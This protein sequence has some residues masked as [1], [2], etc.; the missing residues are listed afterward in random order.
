VPTREAW[1]KTVRGGGSTDD[2]KLVVDFLVQTWQFDSG[3]PRGFQRWLLEQGL[4]AKNL[5]PLQVADQ[6]RLYALDQ[7]ARLE[8]TRELVEALMNGVH[9]PEFFGSMA[10]F[11]SDFRI[12][13]YQTAATAYRNEGI[14]YALAALSQ[15]SQWVIDASTKSFTDKPALKAF[16]SFS[17]LKNTRVC[18]GLRTDRTAVRCDNLSDIDRLFCL[19]TNPSDAMADQLQEMDKANGAKL[20]KIAE[21]LMKTLP[22]RGFGQFARVNLSLFICSAGADDELFAAAK[23]TLISIAE[24]AVADFLGRLGAEYVR[25]ELSN[26]DQTFQPGQERFV[27][28]LIDAWRRVCGDSIGEFEDATRSIKIKAPV[29]AVAVSAGA[30]SKSERHGAR[31]QRLLTK[32]LQKANDR[33]VREWL[34][35]NPEFIKYLPVGRASLQTVKTVLDAAR[36]VPAQAL[37]VSAQIL[38]ELRETTPLEYWEEALKAL[39]AIGSSEADRVFRTFVS[40][41]IKT[42]EGSYLRDL[43]AREPAA[44]LLRRNIES[45]LECSGEQEWGVL[46]EF[47]RTRNTESAVVQLLDTVF[48]R[49]GTLAEWMVGTLVPGLLESSSLS[50]EFLRAAT[51]VDMS[52]AIAKTLAAKILADIEELVNFRETWLKRRAE[53]KARVFSRVQ[54][55]LRIAINTTVPETRLHKQLEKALSATQDWAAAPPPA[56]DPVITTTASVALPATLPNEDG[57]IDLFTHRM[58]SAVEF[59]LTAAKNPW[60]V[61]VVI[62]QRGPWPK[63]E[64]LIRQIV[65]RYVHVAQVRNRSLEQLENLADTVRTELATALREVLSDIETEIAGYFAFRDILDHNGLHPVMNKLGVVVGQQELSSEKHKVMRDPSM[66]GRLRVFGLGIEVNGRVLS[67]GLLMNSGE[68]DD[69]D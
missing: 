16:S 28:A 19:S 26:V 41:R 20:V 49:G 30:A 4:D 68:D 13:A 61:E 32:G 36:S 33:T 37:A 15:E 46:F 7:A 2:L 45:L 24:P 59:A 11:S 10:R 66:R 17:T 35:R 51:S 40:G 27:A 65:D 58:P 64:M 44:A 8:P 50:S 69:S 5:V 47:F 63:A 67:G 43:L 34:L 23:D 29:I 39:A 18:L 9:A 54:T 25:S 14:A 6:K 22:D 56:I 21:K 12:L 48:P 57:L 1:E 3:D 53:I 31:F 52:A 62:R 55:G 38:E 42:G 60:V